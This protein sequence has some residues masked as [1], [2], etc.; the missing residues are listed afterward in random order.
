MRT[1]LV[2]A[3]LALTF[4]GGAFAAPVMANPTSQAATVQSAQGTGVVKAVDLSTGSITIKHEPIATLKW[5]AMTMTFK[6]KSAALLNGITVGERVDFELTSDQ[7]KPIVTAIG[8]R[9]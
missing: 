2:V 7:G 4:M 1:N 5:P 6:T 9:S 8:P 3:A